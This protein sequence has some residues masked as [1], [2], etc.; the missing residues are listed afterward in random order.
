M[1]AALAMTGC[2]A[3]PAE[4]HRTAAVAAAPAAAPTGSRIPRAARD[5]EAPG[6]L[7]VPG[8]ALRATGRFDTA[9]ALRM[10]VPWVY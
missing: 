2:A 10:L 4:G 1:A 3:M 9:S 7:I 8:D 5:R 6:T